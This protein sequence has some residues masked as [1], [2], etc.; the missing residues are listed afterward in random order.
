MTPLDPRDQII[1]DHAPLLAAPRFG[2]LPALENGRHRFIMARYGP[3]LEVKRPWLHGLFD[4]LSG[5]S[6]LDM[7]LP[8]GD[9][10]ARFDLSFD[11]HAD[12]FPLVSTFIEAAAQVA[13]QEHAAW[14][15]WNDME[16]RLE[17]RELIA[18]SA[19]GGGISYHYPKLDPHLSLAVDLHSHGAMSA[20]FSATDDEDDAG[21]VKIAGVIGKLGMGGAPEWQF[22]LCALGLLRELDLSDVQRCSACGCTEDNPCLNGCWWVRPDLCSACIGPF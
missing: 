21:A 3:Y 22:R 5:D 15:L 20:F 6:G 7:E 9:I 10:D 8:Y 12:V 14:L 2:T 1:L 18:I 19:S 13:P 4:L 11:W 16:R 17:Y